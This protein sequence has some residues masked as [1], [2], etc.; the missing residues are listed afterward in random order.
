MP[1]ELS[2]DVL[3]ALNADIL[4]PIILFEQDLPD[5]SVLRLWD[6]NG[7]LSYNDKLYLGNGWLTAVSPASE[8][9]EIKSD[10]FQVQLNSVPVEVIS[11]VLSSL[12]HGL[13]GRIY[14][15]ALDDNG[16]VLFE[17]Y[18]MC[19]GWLDV[20]EFVDDGSSAFL[21]LSYET[22]IH[23]LDQPNETRY[24]DGEQQ[25]LFPGDKGFEHVAGIQDKRIFWGLPADFPK[26]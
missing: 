17:P 12:R 9:S 18:L 3:T 10:G 15:A 6:G 8:D 1:R 26:K 11:I 14:F 24:T 20:P 23:D 21:T 4:R 5:A 2:N 13:E 19:S 16:T 25:R 7:P 22:D